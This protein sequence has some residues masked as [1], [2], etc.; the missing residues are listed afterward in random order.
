MQNIKINIG[1]STTVS[2]P[3]SS[4]LAGF[5]KAKKGFDKF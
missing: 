4:R 3:E 5:P 1:G 2:P